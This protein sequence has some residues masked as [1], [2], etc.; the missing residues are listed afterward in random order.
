[1]ISTPSLHP[2]FSHF[3]G[4]LFVAGCVLLYLSKKQ[5]RPILTGAASLNFTFGLLAATLAILTGMLA[6]DLGLR[7]V[8]EVEGHQ[9]YS[10]VMVLTYGASTV[11]SYTNQFSN[12]AIWV[13]FA[14]FIAL[15]ATYYSGY[16]LVFQSTG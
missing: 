4:A 12:A 14:N 6:S 16:L 11:Y 3:P 13:Y 7:Q 15:G 9:G 10:F 1:M 2:L 8:T 5:S